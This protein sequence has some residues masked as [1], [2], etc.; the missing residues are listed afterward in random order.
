MTLQP[1]IDATIAIQLHT[2][3]AILAFFLGGVVLFRRK[4]DRLHRI[5]GRIWVALM[6]AVAITSFFIHTIQ[7]VGIWSPIHL[8]SLATL[9]FLGRG[10]WLARQ[11]RI[12]DHRKVMQA[13]YMGALIV[14]GFFTFMP[15]RIMYQVFFG[16]PQ[17]MAGVA[18][19]AIVV[20]G[21]SFSYSRALPYPDMSASAD[22]YWHGARLFHGGKGNRIILTGGRMPWAG[23]GLTE[24]ESG[25]VFLQDLGVPPEAMLLD[26]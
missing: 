8:L 25:A 17:P 7:M 26:R 24:A 12:V 14:A 9:W 23:P 2:V 11:K 20:L 5:G 10:V 15:G 21:G 18:V 3:T 1:L 13:T 6:L 22:R 4:G 19:A 16:G